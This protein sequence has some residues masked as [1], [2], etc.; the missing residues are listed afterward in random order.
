MI[1]SQA[2]LKIL[3]ASCRSK[4]E[5]PAELTDTDPCLVFMAWLSGAAGLVTGM[6]MFAAVGLVTAL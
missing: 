3:P 6:V 1:K 2:L 4:A 5:A